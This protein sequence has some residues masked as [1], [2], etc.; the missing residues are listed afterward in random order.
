MGQAGVVCAMDGGCRGGGRAGRA[1]RLQAVGQLIGQGS[2]ARWAAA[3][4]ETGPPRIA[5]PAHA[6]PAAAATL[7]PR[8][9]SVPPCRTNGGLSTSISPAPPRRRPSARCRPGLQ[10]AACLHRP[11]RRSLQASHPT[12]LTEAPAYKNRQGS[13]NCATLYKNVC[14]KSSRP[15]ASCAAGRRGRLAAAAL[16]LASAAQAAPPPAPPHTLHAWL[17][18]P[19]QRTHSLR[20]AGSAVLINPGRGV[21]PRP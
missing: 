17:Q 2:R 9:G 16:A 19:A 5:Q 3:G 21:E 10:R 11:P 18:E 13:A 4:G 6:T 20:F 15:S 14:Q 7:P 8:A 1:A 12:Q